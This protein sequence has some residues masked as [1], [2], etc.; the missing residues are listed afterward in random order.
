MSG[1]VVSD[2]YI[3]VHGIQLLPAWVDGPERCVSYQNALR[4]SNKAV[5]TRLVC[6]IEEGLPEG[7]G[8]E[9]KGGCGGQQ[10]GLAGS[11]QN[12]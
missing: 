11:G 10:P 12:P 5:L 6:H 1:S 9:I 4:R 3:A 7:D 8:R 2:V